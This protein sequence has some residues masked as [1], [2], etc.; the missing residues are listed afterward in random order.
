[1]LLN[2]ANPGNFLH[3]LEDVEINTDINNNDDIKIL[4]GSYLDVN[5]QSWPLF[6]LPSMKQISISPP[7]GLEYFIPDLFAPGLTTL[8]LHHSQILERDLGIVLEKTPSLKHL[9]YD[10]W[11]DYGT[12]ESPTNRASSEIFCCEDLSR[13]LAHVRNLFEKLE[14]R[15]CFFNYDS[16]FICTWES[17]NSDLFSRGSDDAIKWRGF[18]GKI[19]ILRDFS[20]LSSQAMPA[21]LL[22]D[23]TAERKL[24]EEI[25][26]IPPRL[27]ELLPMKSL[28]DIYLSDRCDM[29]GLLEPDD[30]GME[31]DSGWSDCD[32]LEDRF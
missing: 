21:A 28:V 29:Y 7:P 11:V 5:S 12:R 10:A 1:M 22:S 25:G 14:I 19:E 23:W 26:D 27:K 17:L 20:K 4:I 2:K 32:D 31:Y 8:V 6:S 16:Y 18:Y 30:F 24:F 13:S 15:L 3:A 9:V